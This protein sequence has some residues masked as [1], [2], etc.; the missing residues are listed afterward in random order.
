M[1]FL[2]RYN[3]I[4]ETKKTEEEGL[5]VLNNR[6][7]QDA[8]EVLNKIKSLGSTLGDSQKNMVAMC[9]LYSG[10]IEIVTTNPRD[11]TLKS[12]F[13]DYNKLDQIKYTKVYWS[14]LQCMN[15]DCERRNIIL[16]IDFF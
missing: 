1:K 14:I 16:N 3:Q 4:F 2:K 7:I 12:I 5:I 10:N 9:V 6:E 11:T 13:D 15:E 8:T